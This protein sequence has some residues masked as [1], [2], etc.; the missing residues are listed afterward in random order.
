MNKFYQSN[1]FKNGLR[2]ITQKRDQTP[3]LLQKVL[4]KLGENSMLLLIKN[5]PAITL[6]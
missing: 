4:I 5:I 6:K 2:L 1:T 3:W